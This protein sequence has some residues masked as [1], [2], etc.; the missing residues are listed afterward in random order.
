MIQG[1]A[2]AQRR[3]RL[4]WWLLALAL[5]GGSGCEWHVG[6][7]PRPAAVIMLGAR[8]GPGAALGVDD[9]GRLWVAAGD[10]L[11]VMDAAS[12]QLLASAAIG[13]AGPLHLMGGQGEGEGMYLRAGERLLALDGATGEPRAE[14]EVPATHVLTLDPRGRHVYEG[15]VSGTVYGL[16]PR[17]LEPRWAWPRLGRDATALASSPEGDRLYLALREPAEAGAGTTRVLTRDVQTGRVLAETPLPFSVQSLAADAAGTVYALLG[18][19]AG[20]LVAALRPG[21]DGLRVQWQRPL[22]SLGLAEPAELRVAPSGDRLALFTRDRERGLQLLD[23]RTGEPLGR[24]GE[25]PLDAASGADGVLYLLYEEEIR[26][27]R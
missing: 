22:L 12:G 11:R 1:Y 2:R 25:G 10:S 16:D 7:E 8:V 6:G 18:D 19:D 20:G 4:R 14:R 17:T 26:I 15:M 9:E 5:L 27:L 24:L 23:A 21:G 3:V 13:A